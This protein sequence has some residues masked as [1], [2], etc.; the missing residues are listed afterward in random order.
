MKFASVSKLAF[1]EYLRPDATDLDDS[2]AAVRANEEYRK[3]YYAFTALG[4]DARAGKLFCG[5]TNFADDLLHSYDPASGQFASMNYAAIGERYEVKIHRGLCIGEDGCVYGATSCLHGI[6]E[7][8]KGPGGKLFKFDPAAGKYE[9]LAVPIPQLYIQTISLDW[10][11][12][13]IYGMSYPVFEFFAF[14]IRRRELVYRQ[15]MGSISHIGA[16]DD[17]GG[18]WGTWLAQGKAGV[19]NLFR[20]DPVGN[21]VKFFD[22]GF[23]T[24]CRNLMYY[25]AGPID[26]ML[27]GGDGWMYAGHESGELYRIDWRSGKVEYLC[28]PL[29]GQRLP[30]LSA[31]EDGQIFGVGGTDRH[32]AGFV[33]DR[34][35]G[36]YEVL[37]PI[38]DE[39]ADADCFRTHDCCLVGETLYVGETDNPKRSCYLWQCRLGD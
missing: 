37:G 12:Q 6:K 33:Y 24:P 39:Q 27:N 9:V 2:T 28:K 8:A 38:R 14:S 25:L 32:T 30:G 18:Y 7:L 26:S 21:E 23:P 15:Y 5:T 16:I 13:M 4:H 1:S 17:E 34:K 10:D 3:H 31:G 11:R 22:Q 20:Y 19:H 35:T 29:P 36:R